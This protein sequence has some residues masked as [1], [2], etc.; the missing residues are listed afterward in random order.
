L[1][2]SIA[3]PPFNLMAGLTTSWSKETIR[4]IYLCSYHRKY[5]YVCFLFSRNAFTFGIFPKLP[6]AIVISF[7]GID[8][9]SNLEVPITTL[10]EGYE[11]ANKWCWTRFYNLNLIYPNTTWV[12][13][14]C[15]RSLIFLFKDVPFYLHPPPS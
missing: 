8:L 10:N 13:S 7:F 5:Y 11:H 12:M 6:L 1:G 15:A 14:S 9:E 2:I 3:F 4:I